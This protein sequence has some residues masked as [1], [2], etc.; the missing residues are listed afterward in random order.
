MSNQ[1][2]WQSRHIIITLL[3]PILAIVFALSLVQILK[4]AESGAS[5]DL[6]QSTKTVNNAQATA[7]S[8]LSYT[9]VV[10]NT[11]GPSPV[12]NVTDTLPV[13]L[14][15]DMGTLVVTPDV[16][17]YGVA[18]NVITW[19]G[20]LNTNTSI[21]LQFDATLTDTL[22]AG[23]I[24][25]N[26]AQIGDGFSVLTREAGTL[27]IT[28]SPTSTL[29]LPIISTPLPK[30][31]ISATKP[32]S[33]NNWTVSWDGGVTSATKYE[34][35]EAQD[36]SFTT[37]ATYDVNGTS[38][39]FTK[40]ASFNNYYYYRVRTYANG[41][42]SEWSDPIRVIGN[43]RDDFNDSSSNWTPVRRMTFLEQTNAYYGSGS[44]A[45]NLIIVVADRWDW[46]IA[47]PLVEAPSLPYAI[48]YRARVHDASNL[49]SG[50]LVFGGDW[51]GQPC[52][53]V[54]NVYR[55]TNCFNHFYNYNFIFYGPL[56]LLHEQVD[57][58]VWCPDCG[59]SP[60]KRIGTT[61]ELDPLIPNG[62]SL[63]WHTY[64]VE[65][66]EDGARFYLDGV[67]K[68]HFTDTTWINEPYFGVFASTDEYK[69][70]IW[71]FDYFEVTNLD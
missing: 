64:R 31:T 10:S 43:Y 54:G 38:Q 20:V 41:L 6:T 44:E 68:Q 23:T 17:T 15:Y 62:P 25:T 36:A 50:G 51:N 66:R 30:P 1:P 61:T 47:S 11:G 58:L 49:I 12:L 55:T 70:S 42:V 24:V 2:R 32:N 69:P 7:G 3:S 4:A 18:N 21:T 29:Y 13:E 14:T 45:G 22:T 67:F 59:G 39:A 48:E 71:F 35:Q 57:S 5:P 9:V 28:Q 33:A 26:S 19:T 8:K 34:L 60:I 56:K 40:V 37:P 27:I 16:G 52:P 63:D 53:E 65:V 46:M